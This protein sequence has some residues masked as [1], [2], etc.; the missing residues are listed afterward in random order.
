[1]GPC[2]LVTDGIPGSARH[3]WCC[4]YMG[5]TRMLGFTFTYGHSKILPHFCDSCQ[6]KAGLDER[7]CNLVIL[8]QNTLQVLLLDRR[9]GHDG[10]QQDVQTI[11]ATVAVVICAAVDTGLSSGCKL[12]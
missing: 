4:H 11:P 2:S 3:R 1:M 8:F 10:K 6:I 9:N 5:V 7:G 12:S